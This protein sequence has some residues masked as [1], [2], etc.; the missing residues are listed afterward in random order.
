MGKPWSSTVRDT[1]CTASR[2]LKEALS[3]APHKKVNISLEGQVLLPLPKGEG[4]GGAFS[5][6]GGIVHLFVW[7]CT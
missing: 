7:R 2:L 3:T 5:T 1:V 6:D 4:K